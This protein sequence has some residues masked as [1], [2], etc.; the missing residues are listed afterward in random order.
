MKVTVEQNSYYQQN[1]KSQFS[2]TWDLVFHWLKWCSL[3]M[4]S[5][6]PFMRVDLHR[7]TPTNEQTAMMWRAKAEV[8][9][10]STRNVGLNIVYVRYHFSYQAALSP[11]AKNLWPRVQFLQLDCSSLILSLV[12]LNLTMAMPIF[13]IFNS[14]ISYYAVN[15]YHPRFPVDPPSVFSFSLS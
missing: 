2:H 6:W 10:S 1:V 8:G 3:I 11:D 9:I 5:M 13:T 14:L 12:Y 7:D 4:V 15:H